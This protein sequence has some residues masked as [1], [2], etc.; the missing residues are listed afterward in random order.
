[1]T[2]MDKNF[3]GHVLDY[4]I[5]HFF[6]HL[7]PKE[8]KFPSLSWPIN[9]VL[10]PLSLI[11][12]IR[13]LHAELTSVLNRDYYPTPITCHL[14]ISSVCCMWDAS[15]KKVPNCLGR[16]H[17]KS[18]IGVYGRTFLLLVWHQLYYFSTLL[19]VWQRLSLWGTFSHDTAHLCAGC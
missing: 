12:H 9:A 7:I 19:L 3:T 5:W 6:I 11:F 16:C 8:I 18:W 10:Y 17:T 13:P 4:I 1:M 15:C 14:L 2:S